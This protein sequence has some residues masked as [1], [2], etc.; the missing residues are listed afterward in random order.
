MIPLNFTIDKLER[1]NFAEENLK[2]I[3]Y[4]LFVTAIISLQIYSTILLNS[5]IFDNFTN[6][7]SVILY[8]LGIIVYC[9]SKYYLE[10]LRLPLSFFPFR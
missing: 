7:N 6:S 9:W 1:E 2:K 8:N 4:A 5:K 3:Y 10:C